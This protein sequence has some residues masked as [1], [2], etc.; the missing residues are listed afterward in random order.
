MNHGIVEREALAFAGYYLYQLWEVNDSGDRI[1]G[2]CL[3]PVL[4]VRG[5]PDPGELDRAQRAIHT[6]A[7][8][9]GIEITVAAW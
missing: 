6:V 7:R 3:R 5:E 1:T 2:R 9:L 4:M 8:E